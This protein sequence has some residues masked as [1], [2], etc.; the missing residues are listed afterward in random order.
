MIGFLYIRQTPLL[1]LK[2]Y[3]IT[4]ARECSVVSRRF[5]ALDRGDGA[6]RQLARRSK[7]ATNEIFSSRFSRETE[8]STR[9]TN[10]EPAVH[11]P[12]R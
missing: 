10:H 2:M 1:P 6:N 8:Q 9:L 4:P 3:V 11:L 5:I 12:K 7:M